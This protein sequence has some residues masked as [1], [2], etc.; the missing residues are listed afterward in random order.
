MRRY[1]KWIPNAGALV[2]LIAF[3]ALI[4]AGLNHALNPNTE[5]ANDFSPS[6]FVPEWGSGI[7]Y[8][9]IVI[10]GMVGFE[11]M[12][13]ASDE[14]KNPVRDIPR[15]TLLSGVIIIAG[16]L[17]GIFAVLAV[18]P[19]EDINMVEGLLDTFI[20]LFGDTGAGRTI[21]TIMGLFFLFS[22]ISNAVTWTIGCNR[23]IAESAQDGEMPAFLGYEHPKHGTPVGAAIAVGTIVT[24]FLG[25]YS[26]IADSNEE[27]FWLLFA[28][29]GVIFL[30]PYL[31]AVIA[32]LHA[33]INDPDT[34]RPFRVPGGMPIA[35]LLTGLCFIMLLVS[36]VLFMYIPGEGFDWPVVIGSGVAFLLGEAALR[37]SEKKRTS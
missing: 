12:S 6:A 4:V 17:L 19:A 2:K 16:N 3:A 33:R 21:A 27:L 28:A 13:A 8:L 34:P 32:F 18:I 25:F 1:G 36:V 29:Q 20:A 14:M 31:G 7:Q 35:W 9:A 26:A 15:A 10:W 24:L 22:M 23:T 11:L 5:L 37:Y 30:T